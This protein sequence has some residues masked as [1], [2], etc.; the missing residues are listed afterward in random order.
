MRSAGL[1]PRSRCTR[2]ASSTLTQVLV[3]RIRD[4]RAVFRASH[5]TLSASAAALVALHPRLRAKVRAHQES[6]LSSI[7]DLP[8]L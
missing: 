4:Q 1:R 8:D 5:P 6:Y 7:A 2:E 3:F